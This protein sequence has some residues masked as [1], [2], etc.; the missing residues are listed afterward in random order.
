MFDLL[1]REDAL[2][3]V[4]RSF[5]VAFGGY[6]MPAG[7]TGLVIIDEVQGF[8][9][10]GCGP[11]APPAPNGQVTR[12]IAETDR[13]ARRFVQAE[14]PICASLDSHDP[15]KPEPPYPPHCLAGTGHDELVPELKW[16]ESEPVT[17]LIAKDCINFMVGAVEL[18]ATGSG[19]RNRLLDWINGHRLES[20]VTVGICTDICVLHTA[21]DAYNL[22]IDT[23]VL[24]DCVASFNAQGHDFALNHFKNTLGF[25]LV[26]SSDI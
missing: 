14:W 18:D 24:S 25:E 1:E 7:R 12:M 9:S 3:T 21:A 22:G 4:R 20:V 15:A 17:T 10:V 2:E 23:A 6:A 16:L 26:S 13:L 11:L 19:G 8:A 5:P